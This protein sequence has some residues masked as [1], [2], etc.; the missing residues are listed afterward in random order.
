MRLKAVR[1][2]LPRPPHIEDARIVDQQVDR[3]AVGSPGLRDRNPQY[4]SRRKGA[5]QKGGAREAPTFKKALT[6]SR[7]LRSS[8]TTSAKGRT[9]PAA[10]AAARTS[11]RTFSPARREP[12]ARPALLPLLLQRDVPRS[13]LRHA[14]YTR[15]P[16]RASSSA[17]SR[18]IPAVGPVTTTLSPDRSSPNARRGEISSKGSLESP[19]HV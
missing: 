4:I 13:L 10:S 15:A 3:G 12:E 18:P 16:R 19:P 17:T 11:W 9:T 14:R 7:E 6:L 5:T 2:L 1:R 8:R